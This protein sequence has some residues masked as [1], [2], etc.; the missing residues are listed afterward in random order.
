MAKVTITISDLEDGVDVKLGFDPPLADGEEET[1]AHYAAATALRALTGLGQ[2]S[3][4]EINGDDDDD[5]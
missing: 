3:P 2:A 1:R 5:D 4:V